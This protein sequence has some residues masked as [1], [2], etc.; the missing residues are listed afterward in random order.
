MIG[1]DLIR[2][3][4]MHVVKLEAALMRASH[5]PTNGT[6]AIAIFSRLL[7]LDEGD[8]SPLLARYV[9]TL[10]FAETDQARMSDLAARNQ[11]TKLS[12]PEREELDNYVRAGHLLALLHSNARKSLK[13]RKVS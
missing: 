10:G 5:L 1:I 2:A 12:R 7:K 6:S 13:K 4:I 11:Q 9:L 8:M 3:A